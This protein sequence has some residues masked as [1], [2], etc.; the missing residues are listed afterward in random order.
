MWATSE[1]ILSSEIIENLLCRADYLIS[2][3]EGDQHVFVDKDF[4]SNNGVKSRNLDVLN[5]IHQSVWPK[6]SEQLAYKEPVIDHA[7]LLFKKYS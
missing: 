3:N 7:V 5:S 4:F 2:S 1:N 6:I